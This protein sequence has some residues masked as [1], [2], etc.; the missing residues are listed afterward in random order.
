MTTSTDL[1]LLARI[2]QLLTESLGFV[3]D[4]EVAN[5][6]VHIQFTFRGKEGKQP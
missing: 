5:S 2:M 6:R 1:E 4:V 3:P